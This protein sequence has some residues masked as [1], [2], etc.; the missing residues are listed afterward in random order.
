MANAVGSFRTFFLHSLCEVTA[1]LQEHVQRRGAG[2]EDRWLLESR[3]GLPNPDRHGADAG[4]LKDALA[5]TLRTAGRVLP[6]QKQRLPI[7]SELPGLMLLGESLMHGARL[8][9]PKPQRSSDGPGRRGDRAGARWCCHSSPQPLPLGFKQSSHLSLLFSW[10]HRRAPPRLADVFY[11]LK[12][13]GLAM[14]PNCLDYTAQYHTLLI[15][16]F[17]VETRPHYVAQ[18]HLKLPS[19]SDLPTLASHSAELTGMTHCA[20]PNS[21]PAKKEK[22]LDIMMGYSDLKTPNFNW[23]HLSKCGVENGVS[24]SPR[25]EC[26]GVILAPCNLC[27]P[28]SSDSPASASQVAGIT[29]TCLQAELIFVFLVETAFHQVGQ[30]DV[31]CLTSG[32]PPTLASQSAGI[33]GVSH[34]TWPGN[35]LHLSPRLECSGAILAHCKLFLLGSS[36]SPASVAGITGAHHHTQLIF[37]F[38]CL[39]VLVEMRFHY[40]GQAGF[41]LLISGDPPTSASPRAEITGMSHHTQPREL[42]SNRLIFSPSLLLSKP[43]SMHPLVLVLP[44]MPFPVN[45]LPLRCENHQLLEGARSCTWD[46]AL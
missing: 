13:Q 38:V 43:Y 35:S 18:A 31:E 40:V 6:N 30:A 39:F 27:P 24:Q 15:L 44:V 37:L 22:S 20:Q 19:S 10:D 33:T 7:P 36:D 1:V 8:L 32:Y 5:L 11:I 29:S 34:R 46:K 21:L 16:H 17:S 28:G 14:L 42:I 41:E 23:N 2:R 26:S 45:R 9:C 4:V 3:L 25:L 12:R